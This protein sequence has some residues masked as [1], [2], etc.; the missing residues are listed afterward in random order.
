MNNFS[1][2]EKYLIIV[3]YGTSNFKGHTGGPINMLFFFF[4][5]TVFFDL[6]RKQA[7][8]ELCQARDILSYIPKC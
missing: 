5:C 4:E 6:R 1:F 8:A 3:S 7:G 2:S